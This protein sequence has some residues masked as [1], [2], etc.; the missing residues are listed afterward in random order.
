MKV[1]CSLTGSTSSRGNEFL[2]R[3]TKASELI[4]Q[5]VICVTVGGKQIKLKPFK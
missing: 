3:K 5:I 1:R 4:C 2:V